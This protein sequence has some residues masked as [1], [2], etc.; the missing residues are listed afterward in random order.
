MNLRSV[1][2][3]LVTS[4]PIATIVGCGGGDS[5]EVTVSAA[6]SLTDAFTQIGDVYMEQNPGVTVKFNFAGSSTLAEQIN[7]GAPVDIFAAASPAAMQVAVDAGSVRQPTVFTRNALAI[8][9]PAGNP[10]D[11]TVLADL[12]DPD[13]TVVI[14]AHQVPCGTA[15][16]QL[17]ESNGIRVTPASLEP[18]VRAVLNKVIVDEADAGVVYRTDV[19][20]AGSEVES[21]AIPDDMNV[22]NEYPIALTMEADDQARDVVDFIL[23]DEGQ[24]ILAQWGFTR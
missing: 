3:L 23:G 22:V 5:S 4:I 13:V 9:V 16:L 6:A 8:A 19:S 18:D 10:A 24:A 2:T 12:A 1:M 14:C 17:F 15:A 11:V 21:I 7:Q 20:A